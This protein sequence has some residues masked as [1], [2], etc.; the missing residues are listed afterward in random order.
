MAA[1]WFTRRPDG[2]AA[3]AG[4]PTTPPARGLPR[5]RASETTRRHLLVRKPVC[6]PSATQLRVYAPS[7]YLVRYCLYRTYV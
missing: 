5:N 6:F 7:S 1:A 3:A 2:C 4:E